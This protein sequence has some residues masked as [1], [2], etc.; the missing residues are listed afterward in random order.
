[1]PFLVEKIK[2]DTAVG[3]VVVL[4]DADLQDPPELASNPERLR[5]NGIEQCLNA[6][7]RPVEKLFTP[8]WRLF[9]ARTN[10]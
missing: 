8:T 1:M 3:D 2:V 10:P 5:M 9:D 6:N 7:Y 4:M